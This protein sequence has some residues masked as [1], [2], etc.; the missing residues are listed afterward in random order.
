MIKAVIFDFD[1]VILES[2]DIKTEAFRELFKDYPEHVDEILDHH[3]R[4]AG[5]SRYVKFRH[6]Y[7]KILSLP[8]SGEEE[9]C[10][11]E[12]FSRIV[13]QKVLEAPFVTGAK[14][15]LGSGVKK[16]AFFIASGTPEKE[17]KGIVTSRGL[18]TFFREVH[19]SPKQKKEIIL[20]VMGRHGFSRE[21]VVYV[22]DAESDRI[23]AEG[24]GVIFIER[25]ADGDIAEQ[26]EPL[27]IRDLTGLGDVLE[28]V[29]GG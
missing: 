3:S 28:R 5:I 17:L 25:R 27:V 18:N 6:V 8:L 1:G 13:L 26:K 15:F 23:A 7:E 4:N 14:E 22:G 21:E 10:L 20:D 19:G 24:S 9:A 16:Y 12:S 11:G 29:L 2:A